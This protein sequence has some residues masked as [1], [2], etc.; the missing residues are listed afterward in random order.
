ML[1]FIDDLGFSAIFAFPEI[2]AL[3]ISIKSVSKLMKLAAAFFADAASQIMFVAYFTAN[4]TYATIPIVEH[5]ATFRTF[6]FVPK[7]LSVKGVYL[8]IGVR[9]RTSL[10]G[11]CGKA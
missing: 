9:G 1:C 11:V 3:L 7:T 10:A 8:N 5:I 2:I 4:R 6:A